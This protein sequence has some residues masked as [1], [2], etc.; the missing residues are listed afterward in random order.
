MS[1]SDSATGT[2]PGGIGYPQWFS[3][4]VVFA[5]FTMKRGRRQVF[6]ETFLL[7]QLSYRAKV[8]R[9]GLE[10]TTRSLSMM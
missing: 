10:P 9:A 8:A 2:G 3:P 7:Y 1:A 5:A 6:G 4:T